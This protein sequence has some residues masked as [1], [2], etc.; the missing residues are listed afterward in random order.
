MLNK[1]IIIALNLR[2]KNGQFGNNFFVIEWLFR[3]L[4]VHPKQNWN[5]YNEKTCSIQ[6]LFSSP[7]EAFLIFPRVSLRVNCWFCQF[8]KHTNI[9]N[10]W[11]AER[12][13][14]TSS[15]EFSGV[16]CLCGWSAL[17]LWGLEPRAAQPQ[18][19]SAVCIT[20][21]AVT[22]LQEQLI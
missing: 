16:P 11:P 2:G 17:A 21:N 18:D 10:F 3:V 7:S 9:M 5:S 6:V 14:N 4:R 20:T 22:G 1:C 8:Y 12:T 19:S 13:M 15:F